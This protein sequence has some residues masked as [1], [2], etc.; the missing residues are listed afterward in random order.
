VLEDSADALIR[1]VLDGDA[2]ALTLW[3]RTRAWVIAGQRRTLA[4][5]GVSFDRVLFESDFLPETSQL[6]SDGLM[7]GA[8]ERRE[9]GVIVYRTGMRELEE[10]PLVRPD[11]LSTQHLRSLTYALSAPEL[12]GVTSV[13][14]TGAEWVSHLKS[15]RKLAAE[16]RPGLNGGF[17]PGCSIFHGMVSQQ[18]RAVTS[19]AGGLLVD[20]LTG[21]LDAEIDRSD[22]LRAIRRAHPRPEH[23]AAQIALAY[24][25][26]HPVTPDIDFEPA[27]LLSDSQSLGLCLARARARHNT[28]PGAAR[29][30]RDPA[31]RFA[32]VQSELYR[33]HLRLAVQRLDVRP[34]AHYLRHLAIWH[35]ESEH[36]EAVDRVVHTLLD[37]G[38]R[39]LGLEGG[40]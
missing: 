22:E 19:S 7:S 13:Q 32:V 33:R 16:L 40:R 31:Y 24:F 15:I 10:V 21:W 29:P 36:N 23:I 8:L 4:R 5:L 39:G 20:E 11:G 37:R 2:E 28:Q 3:Y 18:K 27:H 12:E 26:P 35:T 34:L 9:D 17:H 25:L 38:A 30:S 1:R 14:V 6:V